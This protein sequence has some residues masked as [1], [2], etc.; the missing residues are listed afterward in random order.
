M[1]ASSVRSL[2]KRELRLRDAAWWW[3]RTCHFLDWFPCCSILCLVCNLS[4]VGKGAS[5]QFGVDH[6]FVDGHFERGSA[7]CVSCHTG[8]RNLGKDHSLQL[9]I[10][11]PVPSGTTVFHVD[12]HS[13]HGLIAAMAWLQL[14]LDCSWLVLRRVLRKSWTEFL[15]T[16]G[17][18]NV[19][20]NNDC[21]IRINK[22]FS[23]Q[24]ST[25]RVLRQLTRAPRTRRVRHDW[26]PLDRTEG[27]R[28]YTAST[29]PDPPC[30]WD[31]G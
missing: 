17:G 10:P 14:W 8:I 4:E 9:L 5:L 19:C 11:T 22:S 2:D 15:D 20:W 16:S 3:L 13:C 31:T 25:E 23:T 6:L 30:P 7:T 1:T 26:V 24:F 29:V 27:C 21:I 12:I 28:F 18:F